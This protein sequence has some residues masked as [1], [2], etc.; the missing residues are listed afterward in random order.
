MVVYL[1]KV[2]GVELGQ[3]RAKKA[4]AVECLAAAQ[5]GFLL[6]L[7]LFILQLFYTSSAADPVLGGYFLSS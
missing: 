7:N 6:V 1:L 3:G 5:D 4:L 2:V